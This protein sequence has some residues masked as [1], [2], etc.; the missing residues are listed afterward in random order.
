MC[1]CHCVKLLETTA[2][3]EGQKREADA[4]LLTGGAA[5][6]PGAIVPRKPR[7][8]S[9]ERT[10]ENERTREEGRERTVCLGSLQSTDSYSSLFVA[11]TCR[12]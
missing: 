5:M 4:R 11:K 9:K 1:V 12:C 3:L 7:Q 6:T 2:F 10:K 8:Q